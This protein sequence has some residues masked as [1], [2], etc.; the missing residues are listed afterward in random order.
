MLPLGVAFKL[1]TALAIDIF[2]GWLRVDDLARLD[3]ALIVKPTLRSKLLD[4][5]ST[6]YFCTTGIHTRNIDEVK[7]LQ[8]VV[9]RDVSV[10]LWTIVNPQIT[11]FRSV[12]EDLFRRLKVQAIE[13]LI[14]NGKDDV[15]LLVKRIC[16]ESRR[17]RSLKL[18]NLL[19][20]TYPKLRHVLHD[21]WTT[22]RVFHLDTVKHISSPYFL[23]L[24]PNLENLQELMLGRI[25]LSATMLAAL[26]QHCRKLRTVQF[27]SCPI[28]NA[29]LLDFIRSYSATVITQS[30]RRTPAGAIGSITVN[31]GPAVTSQL[32]A[33]ALTYNTDVTMSTIA[34]TIADH[35][36]SSLLKLCLVGDYAESSALPSHAL[37][38]AVSR[39]P[40]LQHLDVSK[41]NFITDD[42]IEVAVIHCPQLRVLCVHSCRRLT[43]TAV[44]YIAQHCALLEELDLSWCDSF[45]NTSLQLLSAANAGL[46]S[47]L[48][49]FNINSCYRITSQRDLAEFVSQCKLLTM[50]RVG[51]KFTRLV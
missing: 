40:R 8:W 46:L 21:C 19:W 39:L 11:Y 3:T 43:D 45:T 50:D 30:Q 48:R 47:H 20:L 42:A 7:Y 2:G 32:Q 22:L 13:E 25:D 5:L 49:V 41:N 16:K 14:V 24:V 35:C 4:I 33:I 15:A 51:T 27:S 36:G 9:S 34:H 23:R 37:I 18:S 10:K 38:Y 31:Q 44:E 12:H 29:S 1:P 17:L 6:E 26:S 28:N